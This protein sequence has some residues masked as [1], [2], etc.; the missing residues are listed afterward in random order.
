MTIDQ[1]LTRFGTP[2]FATSNGE[3]PFYHHDAV[4]IARRAPLDRFEGPWG[5]RCFDRS[6]AD[7]WLAAEGVPPRHMAEASDVVAS[8]YHGRSGRP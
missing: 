3:R 7:E 8:R 2:S 1:I 6:A 5:P 4:E